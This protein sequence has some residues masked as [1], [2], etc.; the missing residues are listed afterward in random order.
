MIGTAV[1]GSAVIIGSGGGNGDRK[2][3]HDGDHNRGVMRCVTIEGTSE[4]VELMKSGGRCS[5]EARGSAA[6]VSL[7]RLAAALLLDRP[8][9]LSRATRSHA[10]IYPSGSRGAV[11]S[12]GG[13]NNQVVAEAYDSKGTLI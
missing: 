7:E 2:N 13:G 10:F 4:E 5:S 11:Y 1:V 8:H 3:D 6:D 9:Q 12:G